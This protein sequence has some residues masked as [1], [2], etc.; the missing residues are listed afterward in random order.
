MDDTGA[1]GASVT[2]AAEEDDTDD[3]EEGRRLNAGA[4]VAEKTEVA[5]TAEDDCIEAGFTATTLA[6]VEAS[7]SSTRLAS[8]VVA[9]AS[10]RRGCL[11]GALPVVSRLITLANSE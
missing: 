6:L 8:G 4:E 5:D 1:D 2:A 9:S 10:G 7:K 11:R 3:N